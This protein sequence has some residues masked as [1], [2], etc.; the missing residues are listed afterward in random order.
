MAKHLLELGASVTKT[1]LVPDILK[2][3]GH[4]DCYK[5]T[6]REELLVYLAENGYPG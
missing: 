1:S 3:N 4:G 5:E 6:E 2:Q